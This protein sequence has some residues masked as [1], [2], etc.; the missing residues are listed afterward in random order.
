[1]DSVF[2]SGLFFLALVKATPIAF[3][4]MAGLMSERSGVINIAIEGMMLTGAMMAFL[5]S[6]IFND[7]TG[8]T[9]PKIYSLLAGL[10][11]AMIS[12]AMVALLHAVF[13]IH[14]KVDQIISGT[15]INLLSVGVTNFVANAYI[16]PR[17]LAGVGVFPVINIPILSEIPLIGRIFFSHQ[18]LVYLMLIMVAVLQYALF[19]TPW[20]LRTRAV[21]EHPRAADTVG[22]NVNRRRYI[23]VTLGGA[24]AGIGG[25][26]LVL[27]SVGRFQKLMTTG[28]GFIALAALIFGKWT[29]VGALGSALLFG[30]AEALGVR[31]Q[32]GD[33]NELQ[34]LA[35]LAGI[36]IIVLAG[37]WAVLKLIRRGAD[38]RRNRTIGILA[39]AGLASIAAALLF[40]WPSVEI[41]IQFLGLMPY[42]A[43]VL[44]LAGFVGRAIPPAA[45]GKPYE[46]A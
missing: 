13:S 36:G 15:V 3:G 33:V 23:N 20:G 43:T 38:Q 28:R 31:L 32:L 29:S 46:K 30:F 34:A 14:Y 9:L 6:V 41:P 44:V 42:I 24:L 16:D 7:L 10:I 4:A 35:L 11:V 37:A 22:I 12:A 26:F 39:S 17:G 19:K 21:G 2:F 5:G 40:D 27:E 25:A 1:M 18:P 8:G 45:I